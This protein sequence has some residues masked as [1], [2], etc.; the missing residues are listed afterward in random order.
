MM[1]E[2][3]TDFFKENGYIIVKDCIPSELIDESLREIDSLLRHQWSMYFNTPFTDRDDAVVKLFARN[4]AYRR[5]LYNW[6]NK[7][8]T[9]PYS[10]I[11]LP[12]VNEMCQDLGIAYPMFQMAGTRFH[13]PKEDFFQ[14][15]THQDV[16]IMDTERSIT[17]WF[18]LIEANRENGT[19]KIYAGSHKEGVI[20]PSGPDYR[21]H[22]FIDQSILKKYS[23]VWEEYSPGDLVVFHTKTI[24]TSTPNRSQNCRWANIFRFDDASDN[25][26]FDHQVN[27]LTKGYIMKKVEKSFSGFA[28]NS[29]DTTDAAQLS[30]VEAYNRRKQQ[31]E[32]GIKKR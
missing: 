26:Y 7:R 10:Y 27:P 2:R 19:I 23:E 12:F 1:R 6:L 14:T 17:F 15:G 9:S 24:H 31:L 3:R 28:E 11:N 20:E 18:P 29:D 8:L 30:S 16:G 22:S 25:K 4:K 5:T 21:G 13:L 32:D